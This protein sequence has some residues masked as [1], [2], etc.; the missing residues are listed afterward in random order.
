MIQ[1][2]LLLI[3]HIATVFGYRRIDDVH[4]QKR[5]I[6]PISQR[7]TYIYR[8]NRRFSKVTTVRPHSPFNLSCVTPKAISN[9]SNSSFIWVPFNPVATDA[10]GFRPAY[11]TC[12]RL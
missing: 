5:M 8:A 11:M 1:S 2:W 6:L 10:L 7:G 3:I 4:F 12:L 9:M